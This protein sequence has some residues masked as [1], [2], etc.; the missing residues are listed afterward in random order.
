MSEP[1]FRDGESDLSFKA[2]RF[3][4]KTLIYVLLIAWT[5]VCLFLQDSSERHEGRAHTVDRLHTGLAGLALARP[6]S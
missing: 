5:I 6:V 2:G 3:A 4:G 1:V